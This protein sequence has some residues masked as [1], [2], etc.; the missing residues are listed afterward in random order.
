MLRMEGK[1]AGKGEGKGEVYMR[2]SH[3]RR[4][5]EDGAEGLV[6]F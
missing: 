6:V 3:G 2:G 4:A 5:I 1:T